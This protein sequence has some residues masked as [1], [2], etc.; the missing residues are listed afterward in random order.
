MINVD[1]PEDLREYQVN[2]LFSYSLNERT[3]KPDKPI[4]V[5]FRANVGT[6][7][8]AEEWFAVKAVGGPTAAKSTEAAAVALIESDVIPAI[9]GI[10]PSILKTVKPPAP[11]VADAQSITALI[12]QEMLRQKESA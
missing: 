3:Q 2:L 6:D 11:V 10:L 12:R 7:E 4:E 8:P 1:L 9:R 5:G